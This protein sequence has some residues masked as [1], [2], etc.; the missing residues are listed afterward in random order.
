[1]KKGDDYG[2][3]EKLEDSLEKEVQ[4]FYERAEVLSRHIVLPDISAMTPKNQFFNPL[5]EGKDLLQE[6]IRDVA[7]KSKTRLSC[8]ST[9][10][11]SKERE[12]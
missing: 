9:P 10:E 11:E 3:I 1:M 4:M 5:K 2:K 7:E 8:S 12:R 6:V